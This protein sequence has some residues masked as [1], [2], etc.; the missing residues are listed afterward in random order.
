MSEAQTIFPYIIVTSKNEYIP[1]VE[2]FAHKGFE[3]GCGVITFLSEF[4]FETISES[5]KNVGPGYALI[6]AGD[7][8][9]SGDGTFARV[10]HH[11]N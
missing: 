3:V 7:L 2:L 10:F 4:D 11:I 6:L 5:L 8:N 1:V 9:Y